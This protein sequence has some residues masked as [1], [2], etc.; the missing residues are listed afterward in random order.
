MTILNIRSLDPGIYIFEYLIYWPSPSKNGGSQD[1]Q[2][3]WLHYG[4]A[5]RALYTLLSCSNRATNK[6]VLKL[7]QCGQWDFFLD[8]QEWDPLPALLYSH[9]TTIGF[10]KDMGIVC[11]VVVLNIFLGNDPIWPI[12]FN[13]PIHAWHSG[14]KFRR[15][16]P[17]LRR[18]PRSY[19]KPLIPGTIS[20][21]AKSRGKNMPGGL[22][23]GAWFQCDVLTLKHLAIDC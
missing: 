8:P 9:T 13:W 1:R 10:F 3:V 17:T 22:V 11:W 19:V 21:S 23:Q 18:M 6:S 7:Q 14:F 20:S 15:C 2:W 12:T 5:Y 4:T 16:N